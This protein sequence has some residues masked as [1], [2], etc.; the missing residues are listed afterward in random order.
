MR[1]LRDGEGHWRRCTPWLY[2]R[3]I[4]G[5]K[6]RD[7]YRDHS[8]AATSG[9]TSLDKSGSSPD[10]VGYLA[11]GDLSFPKRCRSVSNLRDQHFLPFNATGCRC[12]AGSLL[13]GF[14]VRPESASSSGVDL[15]L[16]C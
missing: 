3:R 8:P 16:V 11:L 1:S 5:R 15:R 9:A 13:T 10:R 4:M 14:A 2:S 6:D 7:H 12:L